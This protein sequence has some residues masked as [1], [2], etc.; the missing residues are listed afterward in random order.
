MTQSSQPI[1]EPR[2]D[3]ERQRLALLR[4]VGNGYRRPPGAVGPHRSDP[5]YGREQNP[6]V[7]KQRFGYRWPR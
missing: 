5:D 3:E 6:T 4:M 1:P 7:F 2:T